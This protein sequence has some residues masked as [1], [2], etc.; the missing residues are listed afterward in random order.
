MGAANSNQP[1]R[2]PKY[3]IHIHGGSGDQHIRDLVQQGV[4][5]AQIDQNDQMRRGTFGDMQRRYSNQKG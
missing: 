1:G 4:M 5:A 2:Q 3:D